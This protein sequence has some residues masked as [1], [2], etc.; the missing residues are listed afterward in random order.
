MEEFARNVISR[1]QAPRSPLTR[2]SRSPPTRWS[3]SAACLSDQRG[4]ADMPV[5]WLM[6]FEDQMLRRSWLVDSVA[7]ARQLLASVRPRD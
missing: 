3:L 7:A 5:G 6:L 4:T 2:W 1:R